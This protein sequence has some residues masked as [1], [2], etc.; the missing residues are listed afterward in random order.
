[1]IASRQPLRPTVAAIVLL[2]SIVTAIVLLYPLSAHAKPNRC[3]EIT[4]VHR[5]AKKHSLD[6]SSLNALS[7]IYCAQPGTKPHRTESPPRNASVSC[8]ELFTLGTLAELGGTL[9]PEQM[10][11][12]ESKRLV[13]CSSKRPLDQDNWPGGITAKYSDGQWQYPN[14]I[15]AKYPDGQWQ[16]PN[17]ITAKYPD[18]Q[19]QYPNGITA[20]YPD[21]RWQYPNGTSAPEEEAVLTPACKAIGLEECRR[22]LIPIAQSS[23]DSRDIAIIQFVWR[24]RER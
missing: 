15:T 8:L 13:V 12:I 2:G 24:A 14:G 16:Y 6:T 10:K 9:D 18:G 1:M 23:G 3:E 20:K 7:A 19:W 4:R 5:L 21:G 22:L 17:G 11:Q